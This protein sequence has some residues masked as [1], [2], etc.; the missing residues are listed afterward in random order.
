MGFSRIPRILLELSSWGF[1]SRHSGFC[2][3]VGNGWGTSVWRTTYQIVASSLAEGK[4]GR[5]YKERT[6]WKEWPQYGVF[7]AFLWAP[8]FIQTFGVSI[9]TGS[10]QTEAAVK[11]LYCGL[12]HHQPP[13]VTSSHPSLSSQGTWIQ[14]K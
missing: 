4:I 2:G 1:H 13:S 11:L 5:G 6:D 14:T 7:Q 8:F 12:V 3:A 9:N 10:K